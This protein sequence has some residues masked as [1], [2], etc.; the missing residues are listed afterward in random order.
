MPFDDS[1]VPS[2]LPALPSAAQIVQHFPLAFG[3]RVDVEGLD[4]FPAL[5]RLRLKHARPPEPPEAVL[6]DR[7]LQ[8][9][10]PALLVPIRRV[11]ILG[12]RGTARMGGHRQGIV[13]VSAQEARTREGDARYGNRFS[14][15]TTTVLHEIGHAVW[16]LCLTPAQRGTI[17]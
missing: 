16:D 7:V 4:T 8:L 14:L 9:A 17:S 6:L 10:P 2:R 11:L 5:E 15:F 1:L 12:T 3:V 13:R